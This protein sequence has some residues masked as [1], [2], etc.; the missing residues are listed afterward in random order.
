MKI[1]VL[2]DNYPSKDN[3]YAGA[4]VHTR[5]KEYKKTNEVLVIDFSKN[6]ESY[7]YEGVDVISINNPE[8]IIG[9]YNDYKP[10]IIVIHFYNG[11]LA[12][13]IKQVKIP[14]LIWVHGTEALGWYRRLFNYNTH[15][16][17]RRS[18]TI[19]SENISK[20]NTLREAFKYSNSSNNIKF[21]FVS[22]WMKKIA[23][24]DTLK[25]LKE[26]YIIANPI[27]TELFLYEYKEPELRKN[28]LIIRPFT[29]RKYAND[30]SIK[31]ILI[32]SK[33]PFFKELNITIYGDGPLFDN[34]TTP[35]KQFNNIKLYKR[36]I[37]N[38]DIPSIHKNYGVFLCPTR[39][40]SQG[41]SM[42]EAMSSGLVPI[43][44]Q[45]TAIP[46]FVENNV[47]GFLTRSPE[48]IALSIKKLYFDE[49]LF[50]AISCNAAA[51]I[52]KKCNIDNITA[53]EISLMKSVVQ[54]NSYSAY[55]I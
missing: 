32:L 9:C 6:K 34:L 41:V 24:A 14:V 36:F 30:L 29:T 50:Q 22:E 25:R 1:L 10:N 43:T 42:C 15:Y 35:L 51:M 31:A 13:F 55:P 46:E 44:S 12:H 19:I 11:L 27:N 52:R 20:M 28:I 49:K 8:T 33:M 23:E 53:Q 7:K 5:V 21:V 40:D 47:S 16:F 39:Q 2:S 54:N 37:E 48:E 3:I 18:F 26:S 38:S 4:F 17:L 45:S